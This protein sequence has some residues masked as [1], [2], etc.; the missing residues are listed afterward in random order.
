MDSVIVVFFYFRGPNLKTIFGL[1]V[2]KSLVTPLIT[3]VTIQQITLVGLTC[4]NGDYDNYPARLKKKTKVYL[5]CEP[6]C[7]SPGCFV[8]G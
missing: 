8:D 2:I 4:S 6:L 5:L 7:P 1:L 3:N